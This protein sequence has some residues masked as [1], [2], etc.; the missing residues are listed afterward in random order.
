MLSVNL[1]RVI[2]NNQRHVSV[3]VK[4]K[5]QMTTSMCE[6]TGCVLWCVGRDSLCGEQW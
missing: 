4:V 5:E 2:G 1:S 3:P 6:V